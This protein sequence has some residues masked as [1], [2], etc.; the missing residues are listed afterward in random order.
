ME[1]R[2]IKRAAI[3]LLIVV[4]WRAVSELLDERRRLAAS[5]D[6]PL[7]AGPWRESGES[8]AGT[9]HIAH[10]VALMR[11]DEHSTALMVVEEKQE[12]PAGAL[13]TMLRE[14]RPIVV[15]PPPAD[16]EAVPD[17]A[18]VP[19]IETDPDPE[20]VATNDDFDHQEITRELQS[21]LATGEQQH[22]RASRP[23]WLMALALVL[24][25]AGAGLSAWALVQPLDDAAWMVAAAGAVC[26]LVGIALAL[27]PRRRLTA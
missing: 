3:V 23:T 2:F 8:G 7:E 5:G 12:Q 16:V 26:A 17:V 25:L 15:A 9:T 27:W 20:L 22:E 24:A 1:R 14:E 11:R 4:A 10:S 6:L 19:D 21:V 13:A 18:T